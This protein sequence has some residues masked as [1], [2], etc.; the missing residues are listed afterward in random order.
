MHKRLHKRK[1][2]DKYTK[3]KILRQK[4]IGDYIIENTKI[5]RLR[6][7]YEDNY[8]KENMEMMALQKKMYV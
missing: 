7:K 6:Q 3:I 4:R 2:W 1:H 8:V 5:M